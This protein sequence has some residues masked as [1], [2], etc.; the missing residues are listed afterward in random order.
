MFFGTPFTVSMV[1]SSIGIS[2][3]GC[4]CSWKLK[5]GEQLEWEWS[6]V[7]NE[8]ILVKPVKAEKSKRNST[9]IKQTTRHRSVLS[10]PFVS[11]N[12]YKILPKSR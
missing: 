12:F 2:F 11:Y 1:T 5:P 3:F 7:N 10:L 6:A 8:M 9:T 4:P